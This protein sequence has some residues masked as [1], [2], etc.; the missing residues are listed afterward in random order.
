MTDRPNQSPKP[1]KAYAKRSMRQWVVI[2]LVVAAIV[3]AIYFLFIK[4]D[5]SSST[6]G[7]LY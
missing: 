1:E 5:G 3:Y 6:G 4:G 2:Y 7:G